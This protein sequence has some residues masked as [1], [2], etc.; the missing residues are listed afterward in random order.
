MANI[1]VET[2]CKP[3][4]KFGL[5]SELYSEQTVNFVLLISPI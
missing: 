5:K 4:K 1:D 2:F 3:Y